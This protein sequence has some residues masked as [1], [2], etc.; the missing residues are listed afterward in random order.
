MV[1]MLLA[2]LAF[3]WLAT[4]VV[5]V[6]LCVTAARTDRAPT[7]AQRRPA[8]QSKLRLIA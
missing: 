7:R 5:V 2:A 4:I 1:L 8:P 3:A 6:A